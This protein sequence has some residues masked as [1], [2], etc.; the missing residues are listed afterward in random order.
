[1]VCDDSGVVTI[2][3]DIIDENLLTKLKFIEFQ[4]DIWF[5]CMDT[6]KM[7]TFDIVCLKKYL[8]GNLIDKK[9][10]D[11]LNEFQNEIH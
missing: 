2:P 5:Y 9:L 7:S 1:M 10:L 3:K 4:E 8:V 6:L 11:K